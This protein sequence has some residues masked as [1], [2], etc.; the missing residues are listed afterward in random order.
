MANGL[1]TNLDDFRT[2]SV[3]AMYRYLQQT[4][5]LR[6]YCTD[7]S[8]YVRDQRQPVR[9]PWM[10]AL[11]A[12]SYVN[13]NS[14]LP[15]ND[16]SLNHVIINWHA[17]SGTPANTSYPIGTSYNEWELAESGLAVSAVAEQAMKAAQG[18]DLF[19]DNLVMTDLKAAAAANSASRTEAL[20]V[21]AA[22]GLTNTEV[23]NFIKAVLNIPHEFFLLGYDRMTDPRDIIL[24]LN[25]AVKTELLKYQATGQRG[26][27]VLGDMAWL[28]ATLG[29]MLGGMTIAISHGM[30]NAIT[31]AGDEYA[32]VAFLRGAEFYID[33]DSPMLN[34]RVVATAT[35][36]ATLER[37]VGFFRDMGTTFAINDLL[38]A[39]KMTVA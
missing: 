9:V 27:G 29:P 10:A 26:T 22:G 12:L 31:S 35:G 24:C 6:M 20:T 18:Y 38:R 17:D 8:A 32:A 19:F 25:D 37:R 2:F 7:Q 33:N 36:A 28:Q 34:D 5:N 16:A 3:A 11:A 21:S 39:I 30:D 15:A 23:E 4:G 14:G 1:I 13:P